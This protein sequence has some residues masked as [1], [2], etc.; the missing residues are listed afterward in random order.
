M[1][2][3]NKKSILLVEDE[4]ILAMTEKMTLEKYG[5]TVI[6]A[7]SGEKAIE[8]VETAT[9]IDLILMDIDLGKGI[10][11][12]QAAAQILSKRDIPVVFLS[13]HTEPE[14]VEKTE[15]ITSYGYVVKNSSITVLDASIKMAFKLFDAYAN[16]MKKAQ[17]DHEH[18]QLL[19]TIMDN[20]PGS[21]FWKDTNLNYQGCSMA[22]ATAAGLSSPKEIIG[23]SDFDL[24]WK[25]HEAEDY[26]KADRAVIDTNNAQVHILETQYT[27]EGTSIF[28]DTTKMPL[29]DLKNNIVGL[30]GVSIDIT[31]RIQKEHEMLKLT[32]AIDAS[33]ATVMLTDVKGNIEY[34]NPKFVEMTGYSAQEA[35]GKNSRFLKSGQTD[36]CYYFDLWENITKGQEWKGIFVNKRKNGE[37]YYE[38]AIIA[39][40]KNKHGITVNYIGIKEDITSKKLAEEGLYKSNELLHTV[41]DTIPHAICWKDTKSVFLGCNKNYA[42][43]VGL[44]D[45]QSIIG[46]TDFDLP[47]H[48][49]DASSFI[50]YDTRVIDQNLAEYHIIE[51]T[52]NAEGQTI[53][54]ETNKVPLHDSNGHVNGI[55]ATSENITE[56][57]EKENTL[58]QQYEEF[59]AM[60]EELRSSMEELHTSEV[61]LQASEASLRRAEKVAKIGNWTLRVDTNQ[62]I[63][64]HGA[65][66]IYGVDFNQVPL[67][68]IQKI[69]LPEYRELLDRSLKNLITNNIPYDIVFK[70]HRQNDNKIVD[71]HSIADYDKKTNTVFGV[72]SDITQ[73]LE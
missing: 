68:V 23:K 17:E 37:V 57:K 66:E 48:K 56:R 10:D 12:T 58:Q 53:W 31:E 32:K 9:G 44:S 14:I 29:Y 70:I 54:L 25:D 15:K 1:D 19:E 38:S 30:L 28:L 27:A 55:L 2:K 61:A 73:R 67:S 4:V 65:N 46:K 47:Y 22:F 35:I 5:Y 64:S 36:E 16:L 18:N 3:T 63:S 50:A 49:E 20:F 69:P 41:L 59:E 45:N 40:V 39:P 52:V 42:E 33:P 11:G 7:N 71:I 21:I 26:R 72:I 13:S 62:I 34:V 60:N 43:M 24:P 8:M 6:T 51:S